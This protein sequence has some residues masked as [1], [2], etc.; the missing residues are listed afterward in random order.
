MINLHTKFEVAIFTHYEYIKSSIKCKLG[1]FG[2]IGSPKVTGN[3]I[4]Q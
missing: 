1:W 4:I 3:V 2:E